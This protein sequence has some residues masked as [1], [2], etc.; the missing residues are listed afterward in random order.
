MKKCPYC[1]EEVKDDAIKC[2]HCKEFINS[3][4][5]SNSKASKDKTTAL[6]LALIFSV[7]SFLYTFKIDKGKFF[8]AHLTI[9]GFILL[10]PFSMWYLIPSL[11]I[12]IYAII[13]TSTRSKKFYIN[14]NSNK[15]DKYDGVFFFIGWMIFIS[16]IIIW[17]FEFFP[18]FEYVVIAI[19]VIIVIFWII[20]KLT[21]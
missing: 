11:G 6:I 4:A 1:A 19:N 16:P 18:S 21:D 10:S 14:Y 17:L 3:D 12:W 13:L 20:G 8:G 7:Y 2:K 15:A 5:N 9:F